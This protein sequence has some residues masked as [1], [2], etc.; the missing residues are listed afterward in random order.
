MKECDVVIVTIEEGIM[1]RYREVSGAQV[2]KYE[3]VYFIY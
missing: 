3:D 2:Y 1:E